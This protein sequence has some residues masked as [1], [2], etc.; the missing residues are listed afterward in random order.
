MQ[1]PAQPFSPAT[2]T[3]NRAQHATRNTLRTA[4]AIATAISGMLFAM[5]T[6]AVESPP[7]D[8]IHTADTETL[9]TWWHEEAAPT[10]GPVAAHSVRQSTFYSTHVAS[11]SAPDQ[12]YDSFTYMSVP[13]SGEGKIGYDS[14]D[15]ADF[16]ADHALTMSW[17][18]FE[19]AAD[20]VVRVSLD[21]GESIG[22]LDEV[23]IRPAIPGLTTTLE[24][25]HTVSIHVPY[26]PEGQR[27]SVEFAPQLFTVYNDM[28][29]GSGKP[30][31]Q[32]GNGAAAVSVE[33]RNAMLVFAQPKPRQDEMDAIV[34][35]RD[36]PGVR[37]MTPG[38]I[39]GLD[40]ERDAH[41]LYFG[42]GVYS[43]G[44][45]YHAQLPGNIRWVYLAPGAYV[46]GAFRF[47]EPEPS[48][49]VTGY[50]VLSG[51]QYVY[52]ADTNNNYARRDPNVSNCHGSCVKM[53]QFQSDGQPQTLDLQGVT[54]ANPPYHSFVMYGVEDGPFSMH[55]R[56][57]QQVG[58]WYWQTDGL[59]LYR[60]SRLE[61]S[62]LHAN[63]DAIKLYHSNI[64]A[65][66]NVI[67]KGEN[68]PV[69][70]WG[71]VPRDLE[72]VNVRDTQVI[73][74]RMYWR[75]QKDNS[76]IFNAAGSWVDSNATNTA[77]PT[78]TM[79]DVTIA[80]T[81]VHGMANCA[82]RVSALQN[83][84]RVRIDGL[85][86]DAWNELGADSQRSWF[87]AYTGSDG[88]PVSIG[89]EMN[90]HNGFSIRNY[91]VGGESIIKSGSNW[92][93]H[94]L[95]R[96][97]FADELWNN[98]NATADDEPQG[99]APSLQVNGLTNNETAVSRDVPLTGTTNAERLEIAVG[100][101]EPMAVPLVQDSFSTRITL[102]DV[103]NRVRVTAIGTNGVQSVRR[104]TVYAFG[105]RI[106]MANDPAGDDYGP[107]SYVYPADGAF[108][109][110][111]FDLREFT[112][113]HDG[114]TIR[115]LT[116]VESPISNPWGG[117][118]IST[119]RLNVYLRDPATS[120]DTTALLP[121]T[122][123]FASGAWQYA[124]VTDGRYSNGVFTPDNTAAP[125][126]P[127]QIDVVRGNTIVT[128]VPA[129]AFG[130]LDLSTAEYA[131]ALYSS[132]EESEGIGNVR[133][134]YGM[135]CW[136]G[137]CPDYVHN[138]RFGGGLGE[139]DDS[140][141]RDTV[142]RDTN[143]IDAFTGGTA[144]QDAL[145][146]EHERAVIPYLR[147]EKGSGDNTPSTKPTTPTKPQEQPSNP[148]AQGNGTVRK[149][150]SN[151]AQPGMNTGGGSGVIRPNPSP[152]A[153]TPN[154]VNLAKSYLASTGIAIAAI[155]VMAILL[156]I[157]AT[158][159]WPRRNVP[160]PDM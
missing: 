143:A 131:I 52:E 136:E 160:N 1:F 70:Q 94:E 58:G 104:Y 89:D 78:R 72:N 139:V 130:T 43:M 96:L 116:R 106:G 12:F 99:D 95:G 68:G 56:N 25:D 61:N 32:A 38:D 152:R 73:H 82:I 22:S 97:D 23:T 4:T 133:P 47:L 53:L 77:D 65:H 15:G 44:P 64:A 6:H 79:R 102:P 41:T 71:W 146:L 156:V 88:T 100:E 36:A 142:T 103:V 74:N 34:P 115:M 83:M 60:G 14:E 125:V 76:C 66:N 110:G 48:F 141:A 128:S 121:G 117:N 35:N 124:V 85:S 111:N 129:S 11:G 63:D 154:H 7:P 13:R 42:P 138:Y 135:A 91:R 148:N 158:A 9:H 81:T 59:E 24:N 2:S 120:S 144:Q 159:I 123:T 90:D 149:P 109:P 105:E 119:Q 112:V 16:A 122:N 21:T 51:E 134:V 49:K 113:Y 55:A 26:V 54:I 80:N 33:P 45:Q 157:A 151:A 147:L 92:A 10:T 75:D 37:V 140:P 5:P 20:A 29:P 67:W 27:F 28:T 137:A 62:F 87:R 39:R 46:K 93:S 86:I 145:S 3:H 118:G 108:A 8:S 18:T 101:R 127:A 132:A 69:F 31:E 126:S 153:D 84:E 150:D 155:A 19:Y 40:E 30:T 107:G 50:G 98:W 57:Y 17:S 114:D